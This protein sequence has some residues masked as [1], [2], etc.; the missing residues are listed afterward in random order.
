MSPDHPAEDTGPASGSGRSSGPEIS[1]AVTVPPA[2]V[3]DDGDEDE[4]RPAKKQRGG[5]PSA[6]AKHFL[7]ESNRMTCKSCRTTVSKQCS[8]YAS[9]VQRCSKFRTQFPEGQKV[10]YSTATPSAARS[11]TVSATRG[12]WMSMSNDM[13]EKLNLK[14]A[15]AVFASGGNFGHLTDAPEWDDFF[16]LLIGDV[17]RP[18]QRAAVSFKY[19]NIEYN[20]LVADVN[21]VLAASSGG[22]PQ[23]DG[24]T[25]VR[26]C[27]TSWCDPAVRS[28]VGS[29]AGAVKLTVLPCWRCSCLQCVILVTG[30]RVGALGISNDE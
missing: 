9:H 26:L 3:V 28:H 27:Q 16:S 2:P 23:F 8:R 6:L 1:A 21:A 17:W 11:V 22:C 4:L 29:L 19:V 5:P 13:K 25:D 20:K 14:Y 24:W 7:F 18:P 30:S 10:L 15:E 12:F